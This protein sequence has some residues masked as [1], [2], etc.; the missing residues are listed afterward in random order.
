MVKEKFSGPFANVIFQFLDS[1][2]FNLWQVI[3]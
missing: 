1:I 3:S 2:M